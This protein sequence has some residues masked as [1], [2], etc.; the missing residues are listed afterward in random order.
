MSRK[1]DTCTYCLRKLGAKK[2]T[3]DHVPHKAVI[4]RPFPNNLI[5]VPA[6]EKCNNLFSK[7]DQYF[8]RNTLI[9][10]DVVENPLFKNLAKKE[11]EVLLRNQDILSQS[12][13][14]KVSLNDRYSKNGI[15]LGK[16]PA[17][18]V[19]HER[20]FKYYIRIIRA[21]Y[22]FYSKKLI[23]ASCTFSIIDANNLKGV[24]S[25]VLNVFSGIYQGLKN[26][27]FQSRSN[28]VLQYKYKF[29]NE[30]MIHSIWSLVFFERLHYLGI[31]V[32]NSYKDKM[33]LTAQIVF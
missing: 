9:R 8:Q 19:D 13:I 18:D 20:L 16:A 11:Y 14:S 6:C 7:E 23:P 22:Y 24:D 30:N 26:I 2:L 32:D 12:I 29:Y 5:T 4:P 28:N 10:E 1:P 25:E 21:L 31:V 27:D 17:Y 33:D 15:Y 3:V